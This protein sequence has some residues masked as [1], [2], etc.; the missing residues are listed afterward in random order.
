MEPKSL[1]MIPTNHFRFAALTLALVLGS[2]ATSFG[3]LKKKPLEAKYRA[4]VERADA[5]TIAGAIRKAAVGPSATAEINGLGT[6]LAVEPEKAAGVLDALAEVRSVATD[7]LRA[8]LLIWMARGDET[9]GWKRRQRKTQPPTMPTEV[10]GR[11]A[12]ELLDHP[13]PF[14]RAL[15]EW[16]IAIRLGVECE[17]RRAK[18]WPS[19]E[20]TDWYRRWLELKGPALLECDYVRQAVALGWHRD[21]QSLVESTETLVRRVEHMAAWARD[22]TTPEKVAR[23]D[24]ALENVTKAR[25]V[26]T[27]LAAR[28]PGE[29][30]ALRKQ[31][32][33]LR[34]AIRDVVFE[35]PDLNVDEILFAT[36]CGPDNGNITNG[37]V[38]DIF[39]PGGD[40]YIKRGL[41]PTVPARPLIAG[42]LGSGHLRGLD[43]HWEADRLVF[44]YLRQPRYDATRDAVSENSE[45]G[46]SETAHL[47]E[48]RIDGS[49]LT[50][51]TDAQH[52]SDVEPCY[53]PNDD[54]VFV[55]DRSNYGSQCAG[56]LHQDKMILNLF[57]STPDSRRIWPLSNNKDFDR[58]PHV[59]DS[60]QILFLHWEYQERHLW[61]THTL[62]TCRPD[63][64]M[65]DAI[66]KQ[67]IES[68]PMSLR[69]ARQIP[70]HELLV[71]IACGHHNGEVGAVFLADYGQGINN[72]EGMRTVTPGVSS[73]EGGYGRVKTVAEGG[74][75]DRGGHYQFPYPLSAK[76]FLVAYSYKKPEEA[77]G[78]DF[79]LYAIDVW[80]NKELIHRDR[81]L[82]V[83][84]PIPLRPRPR[85]PVL[86]ENLATVPTAGRH[87]QGN[88]A[89]SASSS[90]KSPERFATVYV[91]DVEYDL[92]G[93]KPGTVKY[94]RISQH[95]PWP[96]VREEK[97]ACGYNDLHATPSGAWTRMFGAWTWSPARVIGIVPVEKDGSAHFKVPADQ[98][99]YFQALDKNYLEVRRM[100]SNVTFQRGESRGCIGCHES[101]TITPQTAAEWSGLALRRKPSIPEPPTWGNR[102]LPNYD[103]D[104]Q[105]IFD[106]HCVN[107]HGEKKPAGGLEFTSRR[108]GGYH[109]SYRTLFGVRYDETIPVSNADGWRWRYPDKPVPPIDKAW[110]QRIE[111]NELPDQLVMLANRFGGAEVTLPYAFGSA[112]SRLIR[113]LLDHPEHHQDVDMARDEWIALVTWVDLNAPYFDSYSNKDTTRGGKPAEWVQVRFPDPWKTPPAGEWVWTDDKTVVLTSMVAPRRVPERTR[114]IRI[115]FL[116][117]SSTYMHNMPN[118]LARW[119]EKYGG[120]RNVRAHLVGKS[121]TGVHAYLRPGF[122]VQYGLKPGE[123][124]LE[125]I[126]QENYHFVVLQMVTKFIVGEEGDEFDRA[127]DTYCKAIRAAGGEPV[128]YEQGWDRNEINDKGQERVLQ[129]AL[130]NRV[131]RFAP[132]STAWEVVRAKRPDLELH[133]LPDTVHPGTLGNYLNL[134]CFLATLTDKSPEGLPGNVT[135]WPRFGS[136]NK[137]EADRR[138]KDC[139][140]DA[141][142]SALP[143]FMKRMTAMHTTANLDEK[144]TA[145]LQKVAWKTWKDVEKRLEA[146]GVK[147][148]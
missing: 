104:I 89:N 21:A 76:T 137:D 24:R 70:G 127:V 81:H 130:R 25:S 66:Y 14:I 92:P 2:A 4:L 87:A 129:A 82:S 144:T 114:D 61:Q 65:T 49:D 9:P 11:R 32:L 64:S 51:L 41:S 22:R 16:A 121:G 105:P 71:A 39:G 95:M 55:S 28:K 124:P 116:G 53:L 106:R 112:R 148:E 134:C 79:G 12:G 69:E 37:G 35:N 31:W 108:A 43:L 132:C 42:R 30:P 15:A 146:A 67:H 57:R 123:T 8:E 52:N 10:I 94:L 96:C 48:M 18:P 27:N 141:Y 122:K 74:V 102:D 77:K 80:G 19:A 5:Q 36:R 6:V 109:Q 125:H 40:I 47:Y 119:L 98:P 111:K 86:V 113:T 103:R 120:Y 33:R 62:W 118:Q 107:C 45:H 90:P 145:L 126:A 13:D 91:A 58:Y 63:G 115:L 34:R 101:R 85:P 20:T 54:I 135:A 3:A 46:R 93:V 147:T 44:S 143:G 29:L 75:E 1:K 56:S 78:R 60:G 59:M 26:L 138:L 136:F 17:G 140:L 128:F 73:T 68:G 100:R 83:I 23:L 142:E 84:H 117:S 133:N 97:K 88:D 7:T 72:A 99:I 110:Y 38:R 131:R 139:R 50:Q